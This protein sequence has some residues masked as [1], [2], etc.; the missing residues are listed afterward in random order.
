V[1]LAQE[2]ATWIDEQPDFERLAPS[3]LSVV[4]FLAHPPGVD[5]PGELDRVNLALLERINSDGAVFL[6][7]TRL[8]PGI[9]LRV[10]IGNLGTTNEDM[11]R[12]RDLL[13]EN[14]ACLSPR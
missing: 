9:T 1:R 13:K 11:D 7:H 8:D 5:D 4:C 12:C 10:A 2:F 14:L 6:S 3:P